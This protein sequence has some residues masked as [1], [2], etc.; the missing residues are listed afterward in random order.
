MFVE[1]QVKA[2]SIGA[3][4]TRRVKRIGCSNIKDLVEQNKLEIVDAN[5]L[6]EMGTFVA[7]GNSYQASGS[8]HDDLMM[9]LVM[10]GWFISTDIFNG[11]TDI[12]MK[13]LLYREQLQAIQDDMLPFGIISSDAYDEDDMERIGGMLW[14]SFP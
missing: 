14:K 6:I 7:K 12:N 3:T 9:N 11:I 4:M 13:N 10:F 2:N 8:N 1:S 5:S